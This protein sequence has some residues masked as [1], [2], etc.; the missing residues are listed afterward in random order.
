MF[1]TEK[2]EEKQVLLRTLFVEK[3]EENFMLS[4]APLNQPDSQLVNTFMV[5]SGFLLHKFLLP[6]Y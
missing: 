5:I 6:L 3:Y 4:K 1:V 2:L